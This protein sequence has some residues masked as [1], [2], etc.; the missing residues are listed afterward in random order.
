MINVV[1]P[2]KFPKKYD[3]LIQKIQLLL[4]LKQFI[5]LKTSLE[6]PGP[7]EYPGRLGAIG[8]SFVTEKLNT[9][10]LKTSLNAR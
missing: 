9:S 8:V 5:L 1:N 4:T 3:N 2:F 7:P 10:H 6:L